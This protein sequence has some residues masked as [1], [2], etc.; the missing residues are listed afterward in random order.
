MSEM[1]LEQYM[2]LP[3]AV[4]VVPDICTDGTQCYLASNPELPGCM[5]HG[6]DVEE[7]MRNL[8]GARRLY[9]KSLLKR[10]LPVPLPET[11]LGKDASRGTGLQL[12]VEWRVVTSTEKVSG[13]T[14]LVWA[15][16]SD[17][18]ARSIVASAH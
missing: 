1:N 7:A 4:A 17:I 9:M 3:Y 8:E 12:Q 11:M 2:A 15:G 18:R 14:P 5:S 13:V 10:H 6:A 16:T